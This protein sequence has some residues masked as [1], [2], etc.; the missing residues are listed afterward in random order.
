MAFSFW[1][2]DNNASAAAL[3]GS[4]GTGGPR[5]ECRATGGPVAGEFLCATLGDL[6]AGR[7]DSFDQFLLLEPDVDELS[8]GDRY[9]LADAVN[10]AAGK[11]LEAKCPTF[12]PR[13]EFAAVE[14]AFDEIVGIADIVPAPVL[15][16]PLIDYLPLDEGSLTCHPSLGVHNG[17]PRL[18]EVPQQVQVVGT[19]LGVVQWELD[20]EPVFLAVFVVER[21]RC[22]PESVVDCRCDSENGY[23]HLAHEPR[24]SLTGVVEVPCTRHAV[25]FRSRAALFGPSDHIV[26]LCRPAEEPEVRDCPVGSEQSES[27][28]VEICIADAHCFPRQAAEVG[29]YVVRGDLVDVRR[30]ELRMPLGVTHELHLVRHCLEADVVPVPEP[31][32]PPLLEY[33]GLPAGELEFSDKEVLAV[34]GELFRSAAT[35]GELG[36]CDL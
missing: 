1:H 6:Q 2:S 3:S 13:F 8:Y 34:P 32:I 5:A 10:G 31:S 4:S 19:A 36:E 20:L 24:G 35:A 16:G 26:D 11:S 28:H 29:V 18:E 12:R 27:H 21:V 25:G 22:A 30:A 17:L 9:E 23:E 7:R 15:S 33:A 14:F